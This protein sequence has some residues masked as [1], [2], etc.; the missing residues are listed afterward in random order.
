M[1]EIMTNQAQIK[2]A[3]ASVEESQ[4]LNKIRLSVNILILLVLIAWTWNLWMPFIF[5]VR[6]SLRPGI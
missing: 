5:R 6:V 1:L 2:K 3:N 4:T